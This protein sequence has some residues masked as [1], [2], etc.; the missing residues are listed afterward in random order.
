V[1][2]SAFSLKSFKEGEPLHSNQ[3]TLPVCVWALQHSHDDLKRKKIVFSRPGIQY[4]MSIK[5]FMGHHT[6]GQQSGPK[7]QSLEIRPKIISTN[8]VD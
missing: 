4:S 2:I 1:T 5:L 3:W 7:I 8:S 6:I